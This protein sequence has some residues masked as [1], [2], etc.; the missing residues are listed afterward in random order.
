MCHQCDLVDPFATWGGV[1]AQC[2]RAIVIG[3]EGDTGWQDAG[4][5]QSNFGTVFSALI[6]KVLELPTT[7]VVLLALKTV[8]KS[9]LS[10]TGALPVGV[11][12]VAN[13]NGRLH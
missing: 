7:K 4:K 12:F 11:T 2:S 8:P 6:V 1:S 13:N 10:F 3:H 5:A 9:T